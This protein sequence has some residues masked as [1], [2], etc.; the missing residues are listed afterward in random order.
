MA[1]RTPPT[2]LVLASGKGERFVASGG[3]GAKLQALLAGRPVIEWTLEAVRATGLPFHVED[4]GHPGMGD[5]IAAAVRAT[6]DAGGWLVLPGDLP[7]VRPDTLLAVAQAL[8]EAD[9]VVPVHA[10]QRG[11]PVG[12]SRECGEELAALTG[13]KGAVAV[14]KAHGA[15]ELPVD[16]PGVTIDIDT[17]EALAAAERLLAAR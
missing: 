11:H 10:G 17:V 16:D 2:I 6:R 7:L 15:E 9:V 3:Q 12:F 5:S 14:L 1:A 4:A 8:E 13:P